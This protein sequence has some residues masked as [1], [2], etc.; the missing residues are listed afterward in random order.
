MKKE[1][2]NLTLSE[3]LEKKRN[4][5]L[6]TSHGTV[7]LVNNSEPELQIEPNNVLLI[8]D[9]QKKYSQHFSAS[10]VAKVSRFLQENGHLFSE[11]RLMFDLFKV[12]GFGDLIPSCIGKY[13]NAEPIMK[14]YSSSLPQYQVDN[15]TAFKDNNINISQLYNTPESNIYHN[16]S[17]AIFQMPIQNQSRSHVQ[18]CFKDFV[19]VMEDWKRENKKVYLIGGGVDNC[20]YLTHMILDTMEIENEVLRPYCYSIMFFNNYNPDDLEGLSEEQLSYLETTEDN[21][22]KWMFVKNNNEHLK[23]F[24]KATYY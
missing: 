23:A 20:V 4:G 11:I 7:Q 18:Y 2:K 24:L 16:D 15:T 22:L 9:I 5:K 12:N 3:L 13:A 6:K 17:G 8:V 14:Q 19:E 21:K 1:E 10:Y